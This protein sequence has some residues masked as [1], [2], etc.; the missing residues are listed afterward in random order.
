MLANPPKRIVSPVGMRRRS[1]LVI[2]M[3]LIL[4]LSVRGGAHF[5]EYI[6]RKYAGGGDA[7]AA[8][9]ATDERRTRCRLRRLP[10]RQC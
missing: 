3:V 7:A 4:C 5:G 8:E 6:E 1:L 10:P 9:L 2:P